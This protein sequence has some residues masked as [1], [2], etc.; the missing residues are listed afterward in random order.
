[1]SIPHFEPSLGALSLQSDVIISANVHLEAGQ[2]R[3]GCH[4]QD[5]VWLDRLAACCRMHL[6][7]TLSHTLSLCHTHTFSHHNVQVK[8][9][10]GSA[11]QEGAV[12]TANSGNVTIGNRSLLVGLK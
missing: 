9:G 12:V 1:M 3:D 4:P 8:I 2:N 6:Y 10:T 5:L 7:H 11:V